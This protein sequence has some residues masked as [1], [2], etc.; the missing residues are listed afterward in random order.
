MVGCKPGGEVGR[1]LEGAGVAAVP[2]QVDPAHRVG[3]EPEGHEGCRS[4]RKPRAHD[5]AGVA[6]SR[7]VGQA[8]GGEGGV[9][10]EG[11]RVA[12]DSGGPQG[13]EAVVT[14]S[15]ELGAE[16][17]S[18]NR[19]AP[20]PRRPREHGHRL[21]RHRI[22]AAAGDRLTAGAAAGRPYIRPTPLKRPMSSAR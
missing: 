5:E 20:A 11:D 16:G 6:T 8:P 15:D 18:R 10:H 14:R 22:V 3:V 13:I 12:V 2:H 7:M 21:G 1:E 17:V 9:V 19:G 4:G